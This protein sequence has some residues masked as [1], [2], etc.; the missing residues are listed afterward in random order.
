[1]TVA[2]H[3]LL[4][5]V[6]LLIQLKHLL[7]LIYL[8]YL[9][10]CGFEN[11]SCQDVFFRPEMSE[12][13]VL[14]LTLTLIPVSQALRPH[15]KSLNISHKIGNW[16]QK[17]Q[18]Q[19]QIL[20]P[21]CKRVS[22]SMKMQLLVSLITD[23]NFITTFHYFLCYNVCLGSNKV[24]IFIRNQVSQYQSYVWDWRWSQVSVSI[25]DT[26][27]KSLSI[28]LNFWDPFWV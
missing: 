11:P 13:L 8:N 4:R 10:V 9:S 14:R 25:F 23:F 7:E 12:I 15:A 26:K 2:P 18:Y 22:L 16:F 5:R 20:R 1:M 17:Y 28:C 24:I 27:D 6:K 21:Q 3:P 19:S